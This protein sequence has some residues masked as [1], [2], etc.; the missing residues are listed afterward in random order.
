MR[1]AWVCHPVSVVA[2]LV[3]LVNDHLLKHAWPG[4]VTGK[5]SD[6]AGLVI[7][8]PLVALIFRRRA[9]AAATL[10]TGVLFALVKSTETGATAASLAWTLVAGPSRVLA[11]STDLLALPALALAWWVRSRAA[12]HVTRRTRVL[13]AMPLAVVAVTATGYV[14]PPPAA[15]SAVV[16]DGEI[17]VPI[18]FSGALATPDG[19]RTWYPSQRRLSTPPASRACVPD[20]PDRCYRTVANRL[21]VEES[22]DGGRTWRPSWQVSTG[23]HRLLDKVY[24]EEIATVALAVQATPEGHVVVAANGRDGVAVRD[25][26]GT[27]RRLGFGTP[28]APSAAGQSAG[29]GEEHA[30]PLVRPG[31]LIATETLIAFLLG[32]LV[33]VT[34]VVVASGIGRHGNRKTL[35]QG[36][37]GAPLMLTWPLGTPP[38][39]WLTGS[40]GVMLVGITLVRTAALTLGGSVRAAVGWGVA[41]IALLAG[42]GC[43]LPFWGWTSGLPDDYDTAQ[44]LA[45]AFGLGIGTIGLVGVWRSRRPPAGDGLDSVRRSPRPADEDVGSAGDATT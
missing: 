25:W 39:S 5:L 27:W 33:L 37:I 17:V 36:L 2:A 26:T 34:G 42:L 40:V 21:M 35:W 29:F 19:G 24:G 38:E 9:D 16:D 43:W 20:R 3:L 1:Y 28:S 15:H 18:G 32:I 13:L 22:D 8:P 4:L 14:P 12:N 7:A 44:R 11:D 30:K 6:V 31:E 45:V 41:G 23:R 10:L